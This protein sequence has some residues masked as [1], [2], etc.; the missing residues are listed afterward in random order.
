[1]PCQGYNPEE[2]AVD[3]TPALRPHTLKFRAWHSGRK[4]MFSADHMGKDQVTLMPDGQGF[5][6]V[7]GAHTSLSQLLSQMIPMQF[8]GLR[9]KNERDVF[10]GDIVRIHYPDVGS[11]PRH[12][13]V[14]YRE[15]S[16]CFDTPFVED[17]LR[18]EFE[19]VGNIFE[20][21]SLLG[22]K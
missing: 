6:N 8:T 18:A 11:E 19:V 5:I 13:V 4:T 12:E 15:N 1:M 17:W 3:A 20:H 21:P 9:D 14:I 7:S 22:A 16:A 10:E 2:D